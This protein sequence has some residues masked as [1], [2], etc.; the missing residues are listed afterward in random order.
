MK[1]IGRWCSSNGG[2][3]HAMSG[4][5]SK[6]MRAYFANSGTHEAAASSLLAPKQ[7]CKLLNADTDGIVSS[8]TAVCWTTTVRQ[9][10]DKL[11]EDLCAILCPWKLSQGKTW[12]EFARMRRDWARGLIK[13]TW[14]KL[15]ET[16]QRDFYAH[17]SRQ[18]DLQ[19]GTGSAGQSYGRLLRRV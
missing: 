10:I 8:S 5:K 7:K 12:S 4:M 17:T 11:Q 1:I 14:S 19:P 18:S 13:K 6:L 9:R 16:F 2:S 3:E 15:L